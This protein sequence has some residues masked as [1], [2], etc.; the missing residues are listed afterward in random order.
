MKTLSINTTN[1]L[2]EVNVDIDGKYFSNAVQSPYSEH[3]MQT[4]QT[5]LT[6]ASTEL[7][8]IDAFGVVT[9]PG[10][11][12]GIR[13]GMAVIKGLIC[14]TNKPCVAINSFELVAYNINDN[15]FVVLLDS[16]N[17]DAYYAIF[18]NHSVAEIG[19]GTIENILSFASQNGLKTYCSE[20]E[21]EKFSQHESINKV[22]ISPN[23]LSMIIRQKAE[24][25]E[26]TAIEKLSPVYIKL[27]QAEIG[28]EQKMKENLSF[29]DA[30]QNDVNALE[31]I[32]KQCF[33]GIESY[34]AKSF[35]GELN[36]N[37]KHYF[38]ARYAELVIGY[39]G[40]QKLGDDLNL[41]KIAV[42]PQYRKLGVGFKLMELT[43]DF[44]KQNDIQN[45]FLEVRESNQS[46]I[47]LYS[48]FGFKTKSVREKYYDGKE[49]ALVMFAK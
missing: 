47:K 45:Y 13:I 9:G 34:S 12:T 30:T 11:F 39:V 48:K 28:L 6:E 17:V 37:S 5:T 3:I 21:K 25:C 7:C 15:N 10:S 1:T 42:L 16:G 24:K 4:L 38:V 18:K 31:V 2:S 14:G 43:F 29:S 26:F 19:F 44:K 32:D 35:L 22:C 49:D 46:A 36:E 20:S 23:T 27:S 41:L 8:D 40:V 33:S